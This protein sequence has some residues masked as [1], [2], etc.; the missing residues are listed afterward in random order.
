MTNL[1][2]VAEEAIRAAGGGAALGKALKLN[3]QAIYQWS[4]VPP[5]HVHTVERLTGIPRHKLRPDLYP[6]ERERVAS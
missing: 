2:K 1:R 5:E 6:A 3:R 4:R